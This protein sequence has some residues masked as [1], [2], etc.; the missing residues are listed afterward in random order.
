MLWQ[1]HD[2]INEAP[3]KEHITLMLNSLVGLESIA[4]EFIIYTGIRPQELITIKKADLG[5]NTIRIYDVKLKRFRVVSVPQMLMKKLPNGIH[6]YNQL[7]FNFSL[8]K[9]NEFLNTA[10]HSVLGP[11]HTYTWHSLHLFYI[12]IA[13]INNIPLE[14]VAE[15]MGVSPNKL[16]K[17]FKSRIEKNKNCVNDLYGQKN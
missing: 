4:L 16:F 13:N 2:I 8:Y 3:T 1:H 6:D 11:T 12:E 5:S 14:I 15:N 7:I 10:S 17:Y 9:L